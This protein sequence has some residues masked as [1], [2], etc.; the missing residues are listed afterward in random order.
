MHDGRRGTDGGVEGYYLPGTC[1][2]DKPL[3]S[4]IW[5]GKKT[6]YIDEAIHAKRFVPGSKYDTVGDMVIAGHKSN[7]DKGER[8]T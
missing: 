1:A 5:P 4:R 2:L 6:T 8:L 3:N 7:L